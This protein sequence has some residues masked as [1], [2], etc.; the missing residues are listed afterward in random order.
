VQSIRTGTVDAEIFEAGSVVL[1][2]GATIRNCKL[3][4]PP[5]FRPA[6]AT[7]VQRPKSPL[8]SLSS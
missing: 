7:E 2:S 8:T 5:R 6:S 1:Q 3:A 4:S